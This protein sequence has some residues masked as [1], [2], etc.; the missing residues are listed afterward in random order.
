MNGE[1]YDLRK[2]WGHGLLMLAVA[3]ALLLNVFRSV[4]FGVIRNAPVWV[5]HAVPAALTQMFVKSVPR[6]TYSKR[7]H[8]AYFVSPWEAP[9]TRADV[10]RAISK[11]AALDQS[12]T[13]SSYLLLGNDD[14]GIVDFIEAS[15]R[16]FALRIESVALLY[17][18]VLFLSTLLFVWRYWRRP[19]AM[20]TVACLLFSMYQFLPL[21]VFNQQLT[22]PL[23]LR[24]MPVLSL[25]ACLH[26][27]LFCWRPEKSI[28][29]VIAVVLQAMLVVLLLHIRSTA[30]WQIHLIVLLGVL[31]C[32]ATWH[33]SRNTV[34]DN[35][36]G[37]YV[38]VLLP[39]IVSIAGIIAL[40]LY[41]QAVFPEDYRRGDQILTRVVWHNVYSGFALHPIFAEQQSL[42]IDDVS[43][44]AATGQYLKG[45]GREDLWKEIGG[46]SPGYNRIKWA[47]YDPILRDM[48]I[49]TCK[50]QV[51]MC[52]ETLLRYKPYYFW[53]TLLW[54]YRIRDVPAVADAFVSTYFGDVVKQQIISANAEL[55]K[56]NLSAAPWR[57]GFVWMLMLLAIGI[58]LSGDRANGIAEVACMLAISII[59]IVPSIAGYPAPH[60]M[61]DSAVVI[62][63]TFEVVAVALLALLLRRLPLKAPQTGG[64]S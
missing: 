41:R 15:F 52:A 23:A 50:A 45:I 19:M 53:D 16:I 28:A 29:A 20:A 63:T 62:T 9:G 48:V 30:I 5:L 33:R 60:G 11:I 64:S 3:V 57:S 21:I 4:E 24:C 7:V 43:I 35:R 12:T 32:V 36:A 54:F 38:L 55:E 34:R 39:A 58:V 1:R 25:I 51:L 47:K 40:N 59:S 31:A 61:I 17:Y 22:S 42:R 14:K 26:C 10:N 56:R 2:R 13:D 49:A 46:E 8:D 37:G 44:I 27:A 6:Y 18:S